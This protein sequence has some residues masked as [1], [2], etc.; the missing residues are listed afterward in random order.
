MFP[1]NLLK[2]N[3]YIKVVDSLE[4]AIDVIKKKRLAYGEPC[5]VT[6]KT[7][8]STENPDGITKRVLFGI[9]SMDPK[10]PYFFNVEYGSDGKP[11]EQTE[12]LE[13]VEKIIDEWDKHGGFTVTAIKFSKTEPSNINDTEFAYGDIILGEASVKRVLNTVNKD[14]KD[15][16]TSKGIY[17][18]INTLIASLETAVNN[19][20]TNMNTVTKDVSTLKDD[21]SVI[22]V[23][24]NMLINDVSTL[25]DDVSALKVGQ[26]RLMEDVSILKAQDSLLAV[27]SDTSLIKVDTI[28]RVARISIDIE[29]AFSDS[30]M[31]DEEGKIALAWDKYEE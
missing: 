18:F 21:V 2:F 24:Q 31:Q 25:K 7:T 29:K 6:Y 12:M 1:A 19:L 9:G 4:A 22:K 16:V 28:S 15:L 13:K 11:I 27:V 3:A 17:D 26:N 23:K 10:E 14:S 30:F 8:P 20:V 5:I